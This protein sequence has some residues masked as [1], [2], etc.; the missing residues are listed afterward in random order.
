[1]TA[2][3][4]SLARVY[5]WLELSMFGV[6]LERARFAHINALA[7]CRDILLF[8]D[9]DGRFLKRLLK[10]APDARI[11]SID[12]SAEMVRLAAARVPA[13]DRDRVT[14][15]CADALEA[16]LPFMAYDGVATMFFL[17]CFTDEQAAGLIVR[18]AESLKPGAIW[19][20]ADFAV[21]PRGLPHAFARVVTSFLYAFFRWRTGIAAR[22]LPESEALIV[23]AGFTADAATSSVFGLLRSVAFRRSNLR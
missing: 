20:F 7:G 18:T 3:F 4:D 1:M 9:G 15:E 16:E 12:A 10:V 2:N 8:G 11:R 5:H 22:R 23:R 6:K 14:F 19:L 21:P 17:D 13:K